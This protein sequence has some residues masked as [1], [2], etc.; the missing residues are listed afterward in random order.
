M[1]QIIVIRSKMVSMT[2]IM[3][4]GGGNNKGELV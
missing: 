4:D 2:M 1:V 3:C